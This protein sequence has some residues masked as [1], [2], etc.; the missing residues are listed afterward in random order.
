MTDSKAAPL[1]EGEIT[2]IE[3]LD[4]GLAVVELPSS[5]GVVRFSMPVADL[6]K[7]TLAAAPVMNPEMPVPGI[8]MTLK[9]TPAAT[10]AALPSIDNQVIIA[11]GPPSGGAIAFSLHRDAAANMCFAMAG[12]MGIAPP[13][14]QKPRP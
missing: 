9:L 10:W 6:G 4:T 1:I 3:D 11:F 12:A 5:A 8:A 7:L 13:A 14:G 2:I